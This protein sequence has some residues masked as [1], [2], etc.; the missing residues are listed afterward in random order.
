[1][2]SMAAWPASFEVRQPLKESMAT[3][4]LVN[5]GFIL[6]RKRCLLII[7]CTDIMPYFCKSKENHV[8]LYNSKHIKR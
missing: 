8:D 2:P 3:M 1:M 4:I 6:C 7:V 5:A